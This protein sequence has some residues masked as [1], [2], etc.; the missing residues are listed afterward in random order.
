MLTLLGV[1]RVMTAGRPGG[2]A[3]QAWLWPQLKAY[4]DSAGCAGTASAQG[5]NAAQWQQEAHTISVTKVL[6]RLRA[7]S[8][9]GTCACKVAE[10]S[11]M[12]VAEEVS[13][14]ELHP[15]SARGDCDSEISALTTMP[16]RGRGCRLRQSVAAVKQSG[17]TFR[18]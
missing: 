18:S 2:E 3:F 9:A 7:C 6:R 12:W 11:C 5:C 15:A 17:A 4:A 16:T 13:H 1:G 14:A 10:F 8:C